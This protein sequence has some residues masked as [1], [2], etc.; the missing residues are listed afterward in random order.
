MFDEVSIGPSLMIGPAGTP[1]SLVPFAQDTSQPLPDPLIQ[2]FERCPVAVFEISKPAG[3]RAIDVLDDV[4][5]SAGSKP[6]S[7]VAQGF[8][9]LVQ[10]LLSRPS[11]AL[12]K[13]I[14]EKVES[15]SVLFVDEARLGRRQG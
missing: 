10:A 8:F 14:S 7:L 13:M 4:F 3:E 11:I 9:E 5:H 1:R 15:T 12:F 6:W 2:R